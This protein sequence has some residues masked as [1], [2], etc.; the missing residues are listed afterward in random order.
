MNESSEQTSTFA[1]SSFRLKFPAAPE[2][3]PIEYVPQANLEIWFNTQTELVS[4]P[5]D[6]QGMHSG[7]IDLVLRLANEAGPPNLNSLS[8]GIEVS[9][10]GQNWHRLPDDIFIPALN[11]PQ[12]GVNEPVFASFSGITAK[13]IR[14]VFYS[15]ETDMTNVV[16]FVDVMISEL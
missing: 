16:A 4:K 9:N 8:I 6:F 1:S 13:F 15:T 7:S 10:N 5:I 14:V 2:V 3:S 11:D 12:P